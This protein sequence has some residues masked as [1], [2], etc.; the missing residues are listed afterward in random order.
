MNKEVM[1]QALDALKCLMSRTETM[2]D[3]LDASKK[4]RNAIKALEEALKQY[5][6]EPVAWKTDD[7]ELYVREDKFGFYSIPLYAHPPPKRKPLT[8]AANHDLGYFRGLKDGWNFCVNDDHEG[9]ERAQ[10]GLTDAIRELKRET[11]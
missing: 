3:A 6:D 11:T 10:N 4:A 7:I 2:Q 9:F 8:E 5:Q 1:K